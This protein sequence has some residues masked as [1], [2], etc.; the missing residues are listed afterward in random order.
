MTRDRRGLFFYSYGCSIC[1]NRN[2][3]DPITVHFPF[4]TKQI[5]FK[6]S[7]SRGSCSNVEPV[8]LN[9]PLSLAFC[10]VRGPNLFFRIMILMMPS[11]STCPG[12]KVQY[13]SL[14]CVSSFF[15][16]SDLLR[17]R[18]FLIIS[19]TAFSSLSYRD[20]SG[21]NALVIIHIL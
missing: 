7:S 11:N 9:Q 6:A 5:F 4:S 16:N 17:M 12:L 14:A 8:I 18:H 19:S 3:S 20:P 10:R 15:V 13:V 21:R 2:D 1:R